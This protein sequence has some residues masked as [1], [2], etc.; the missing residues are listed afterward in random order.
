MRKLFT[1]A[2]TAR[3]LSA[4]RFKEAT[5]E[6]CAAACRADAYRDRARTTAL[7]RGLRI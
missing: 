1:T 5:G 3:S 6:V 4:V 2:R 7:T